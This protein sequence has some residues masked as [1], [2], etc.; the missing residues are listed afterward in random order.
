[1]VGGREQEVVIEQSEIVGMTPTS[2]KFWQRFNGG[3]NLGVIYSKGNQSTQYS[4]GSSTE[5]IRER[6]N[7]HA[8]YD[9]SLSSSTGANVSTRNYIDLG[10]RHLLPW[11]NWFY[12]GLADFL[13]ST[14]Q[15]IGLQ[16]TVGGGIGRYLTNTDRAS[17]AVFAGLAW[18][19]TSYRQTNL[20]PSE[21]NVTAALF[22]AQAKLFRF[23][24]TDFA[25]TG[26]L[27]PALSDPGRLRFNT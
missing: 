8:S 1:V 19:N 2:K 20:P 27:L 15:G 21:Q 25:V 7:A 11:N 26:T 4:L 5:Y 3:I 12:S 24:K 14:E 22:W 6:W 9:S 18:Q 16:S 10:A 17:V 13:Q 23:S